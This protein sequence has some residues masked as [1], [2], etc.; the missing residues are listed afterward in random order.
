KVSVGP[1]SSDAASGF[2]SRITS[3][4]MS[5]VMLAMGRDSSAP[6][7]A[8]IPAASAPRYSSAPATLIAHEPSGGVRIVAGAGGSGARSVVVST[9][10][11]GSGAER[12]T[13]TYPPTIPTTTS[14]ARPTMSPRR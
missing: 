4:V 3:A 11:A 2:A 14:V 1:G 7:V 9:V 10:R 5:L 6:E 12:L 13:P 8:Q